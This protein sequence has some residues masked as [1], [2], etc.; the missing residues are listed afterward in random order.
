MIL[1]F[2]GGLQVGGYEGM[3]SFVTRTSISCN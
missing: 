2:T 3:S 1:V